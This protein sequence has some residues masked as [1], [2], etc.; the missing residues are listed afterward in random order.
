M[1]VD[2]TGV[3]SGEASL[4]ERDSV[5]PFFRHRGDSRPHWRKLRTAWTNQRIGRNSMISACRGA[6]LHPLSCAE[7]GN[8][9]TAVRRRS[10]WPC[11]AVRSFPTGPARPTPTIFYRPAGREAARRARAV[12][13]VRAVPSRLRVA[14]AVRAAARLA[15]PARAPRA[16]KVG[17]PLLPAPRRRLQ[18]ICGGRCP[19]GW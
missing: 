13:A 8:H 11:G 9:R 2:V 16:V 15:R 17:S 1:R 6:P 3:A 7:I 5:T 12:P 18:H 19:H 10:S 4:S 14:R